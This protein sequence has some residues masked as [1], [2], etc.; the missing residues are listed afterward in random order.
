MHWLMDTKAVKA[1]T[2]RRRSI[3]VKR[4]VCKEC[5]AVETFH[6]FEE[7]R[8]KCLFE[9]QKIYVF[10]IVQTRIAVLSFFHRVLSTTNTRQES[11]SGTPRI[12]F[13]QRRKKRKRF[14]YARKLVFMYTLLYRSRTMLRSCQLTVAYTV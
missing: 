11:R 8:G 5:G 10:V 6:S 13:K 7:F 9:I 4:C 14:F 12:F 2:G 1:Q 3:P